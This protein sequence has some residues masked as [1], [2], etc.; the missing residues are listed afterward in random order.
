MHEEDILNDLKKEG[1][2]E[3]YIWKDSPNFVYD[4]H[5]HEYETK[6]RMLEGGMVLEIDGKEENLNSGQEYI[7]PAWKYHSAKVGE[8]GARYAVGE[9]KE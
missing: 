2:K 1:Y 8:D 4:K 3:V 9:D 5:C 6:L 7:I